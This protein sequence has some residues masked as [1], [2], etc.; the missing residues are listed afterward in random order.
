M[1]TWKKPVAVKVTRWTLLIHC[2][3]QKEY[4]FLRPRIRKLQTVWNHHA[5][6]L[7][8]ERP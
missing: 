4:Q 7:G 1:K 3:T 6:R 5:K 2:R 8:Y